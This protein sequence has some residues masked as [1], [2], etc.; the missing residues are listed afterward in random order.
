MSADARP[1]FTKGCVW[2][3]LDP[4][5]VPHRVETELAE[6][7]NTCVE[8]QVGINSLRKVADSSPDLWSR[9]VAL[10]S[11][12]AF[13]DGFVQLVQVEGIVTRQVD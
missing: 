2:T 4:N 8:I 3:C 7:T 13:G 12:V 6:F 11:L 10:F 9:T 5:L 1:F